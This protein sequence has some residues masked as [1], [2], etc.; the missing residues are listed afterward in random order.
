MLLKMLILILFSNTSYC[1][2]F[3]IN[4]KV[5]FETAETCSL[6]LEGVWMVNTLRTSIKELIKI[7]SLQP[8][9]GVFG[10]M[11]N[12]LTI[13]VL[14]SKEMNNSFNKLILALSVFDSIFIIFVTFEYTLVRGM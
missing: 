7:F 8:L 14:S 12:L 5:I 6:H 9:A 1:D 4:R 11:G 2:Q 13:T 3:N 10:L